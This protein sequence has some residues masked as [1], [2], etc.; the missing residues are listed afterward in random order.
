[1]AGPHP[2]SAKVVNLL[3][4]MQKK[5]TAEGEKEKELYDKFMCYCKGS[6]GELSST[7]SAAETKVPALGSDIEAAEGKLAQLK[8]ELKQAQVDRS[9]A[10]QAISKADHI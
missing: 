2:Y 1:M 7:I 3:Q 10:K 8:E 4:A 6:G 5:V 9:A